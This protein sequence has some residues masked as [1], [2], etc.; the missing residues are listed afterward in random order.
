MYYRFFLSTNRAF[1]HDI[2][3]AILVFQDNKTAAM[4]VY[5]TNPVGVELFSHVN[6]FF[7]SNKFAWLLDAWVNMLYTIRSL[8]RVRSFQSRST[9]PRI[10][11]QPK[12]RFFLNKIAFHFLCFGYFEATP[13]Q[14]WRTDNINRKP[15]R[16]V[17]KRKSKFLLILS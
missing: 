3:A 2:M 1:S 5:Q 6:T 8:R 17:T 14:N 15:H 11:I 12:Y 10:K 16:K 7:C 13:T 9:W 4:L